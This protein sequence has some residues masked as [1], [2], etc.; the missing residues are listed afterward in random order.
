MVKARNDDVKSLLQE[1]DLKDDERAELTEEIKFYIDLATEL[2]NEDMQSLIQKITDRKDELIEEANWGSA[3]AL[4]DADA[5]AGDAGAGDAGAGDAGAGSGDAGAGSGDAGAG[6]GDAGDG[7]KDAGDAAAGGSGDEKAATGDAAAEEGSNT[8][9]IGGVVAVL[10]L[11]GVG[12]YMK[13]K[14]GEEISDD[15]LKF[16]EKD[17]TSS[18]I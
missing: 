15:Y 5:G 14:G 11:I 6:S 13:N 7:S 8:L 4:D 1:G 9:L 17:V 3:V 18:L 12:V 10:G 2:K 16:T